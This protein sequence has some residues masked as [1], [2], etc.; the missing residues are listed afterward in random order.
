[1]GK[2]VAVVFDSAGTLLHMY[3]VAKST[4]DGKIL[5][6]IETTMLV[7]EYPGRALIVMHMNCE[8][9]FNKSEDITIADFII[10]NNIEIDIVC[11]NGD[12]SIEQ[13]RAIIKSSNV[14]IS[15]LKEVIC[16]VRKRCPNIFYVEAGLIVDKD[17]EDI[18]YVL[19][20]GGRLFPCSR[21]VLSWLKEHGVDAYI[22]SGDSM[23][24]LKRLA[25][26]LEIPLEGVYDIATPE[27]KKNIVKELQKQYSSV[28][29]VGDGLNDLLALRAADVAVVTRQQGDNRPDVLFNVADRVIDDIAEVID[30]V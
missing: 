25:K 20:T 11:S 4:A 29:M 28:V 3:R 30:I 27:D 15:D 21:K 26:H 13:T 8:E 12:F 7:A 9:I 17:L 16:R 22:A 18:S 1:M 24:N 10:R 14:P 19:S 2:K 23:W 6:D 5:E